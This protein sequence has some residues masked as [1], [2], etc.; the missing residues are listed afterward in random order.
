M[1]EG[2]I[3]FRTA[4]RLTQV[5]AGRPLTLTDLRWPSCATVD[6]TGHVTSEVVPRGKHLLHRTES[7]WTI[8]S[9]L[10]MEGEWRIERAGWRT[11]DPRVRALV[12]TAAYTAVGWSLGMLDV[13]RTRDEN[14]LVGHLGPDILGPDWDAA[15]AVARLAA[16]DTTIGAALLDQTNLAGI[17]TIWSS[18][19]LFAQRLNPWTPTADLSV[20]Q[21]NA[22]VERARAMMQRACAVGP[23]AI[24]TYVHGRHHRPCQR[25]RT[26]IALAPIGPPTRER[27][28]FHCP[29]CQGVPPSG[30]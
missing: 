16:A 10:R 24:K 25:C 29:H 9:H 14:A 1:P 13:V 20:A 2:D 8:H 17:G 11:R 18:E 19:S 23:A 26:P 30:R 5:F 6:L 21:L 27:P 12:G 15:L 22:L 7:G 4:A 3:L 28:M